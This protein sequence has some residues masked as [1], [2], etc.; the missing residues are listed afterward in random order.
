MHPLLTRLLALSFVFSL[1][2]PGFAGAQAH[3]TQRV[4]IPAGTMKPFY[5]GVEEGDLKMS[6]FLFD[7]TPVTEAQ[8]ARFVQEH[9]Q[10]APKRAPK[11]FVDER[12]LVQWGDQSPEQI[13]EGEGAQL[14]VVNVSWHAA[15]AYCDWAGGRL[16]TEEEWE[17]AGI[18]GIQGSA[19]N[20]ALVQEQLAWYSRPG[21]APLR[22]VRGGTPSHLGVYDQHTL[23]WEW[24]EDFNSSMVGGGRRSADS[25]VTGSFCGAGAI[26]A[27][28]P[29][30]YASF[31]RYAHRSSV[32]A[33]Y[34]SRNLGFR[35]AADI[36]GGK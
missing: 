15:R 34:A 7:E 6:A 10:W 32:N 1:I 4:V 29:K 14:P 30:D 33:R 12:Y 5:P 35:C 16:P 20:D 26:D 27:R 28:D 8:Y 18:A 31:L 22:A 2:G 3:K 17:Y 11:L 13:I 9:P 24:I 36:K 21:N 19:A 23:V 25:G